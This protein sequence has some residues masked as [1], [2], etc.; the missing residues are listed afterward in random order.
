MMDE[1]HES[2]EEVSHAP[3]LSLNVDNNDNPL[4]Y[5]PAAKNPNMAPPTKNDR[6]QMK[7]KK[8]TENLQKLQGKRRN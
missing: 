4:V 7:R 1:T 3:E 6:K 5:I 8:S 2:L